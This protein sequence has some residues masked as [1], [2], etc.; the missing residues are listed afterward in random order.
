ETA[1]RIGS[2]HYVGGV[3]DTG[4]GHIHPLKLL[5]GTARVAAASGARLHESTRATAI[6]R[7]AGRVVVSTGRGTITAD[8][9]LVAVNAHVGELEPATAAHIMPIGSFIGATAPLPADSTVLPG[10]ESVSD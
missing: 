2:T 7:N 5:V 1:E 8:K 9:C 6:G 3:R 10:G 4:T